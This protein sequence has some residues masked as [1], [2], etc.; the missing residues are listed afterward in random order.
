[1][2]MS[3]LSKTAELSKIYTNHCVRVTGISILSRCRFNNKEVM[4][5]S[6]HK[7]VQSLTVYQRVQDERKIEMGK[8]LS[9]AMSKSDDALL[10]E[11]EAQ[12][13]IPSLPPPVPKEPTPLKAIQPPVEINA[14][15]PYEP[16]FDDD[17]DFDNIDWLK[18]LCDMEN[19]QEVTTPKANTSVAPSTMN[20]LSTT[21]MQQRNSPMFAGCKIGTININITKK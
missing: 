3:K 12:P 6:G 10:Q 2:F 21:M 17:E 16:N 19:T 14:V 9:S 1:M 20:T 15:V 13:K 11:I 7:S 8:V 5:M 4:S 18:V